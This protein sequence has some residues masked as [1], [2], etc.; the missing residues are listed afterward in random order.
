MD[1]PIIAELRRIKQQLAERY[2][3]DIQKLGDA[4][5]TAQEA[6]EVPVVSY[7]PKRLPKDRKAVA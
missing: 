3:Y 6:S 1:D 2:A 7:P 4:L 5:R